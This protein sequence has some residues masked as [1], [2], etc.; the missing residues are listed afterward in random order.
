M[1][2]TDEDG[3]CKYCTDGC[4][5]CDARKLSDQKPVAWRAKNTYESQ[6]GWFYAE[7]HP[8]GLT[9]QVAE[10]LYTTPPQRAWAGLTDEDRLELA[11]AQHGWED[12]LIAAEIKLKEKNT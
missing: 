10:L 12:L 1:S 7:W 5:A 11:N 9:P 4:P 6:E 3:K 2:N 8:D